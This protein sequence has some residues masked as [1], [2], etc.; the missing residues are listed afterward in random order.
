MKPLH[1][2][3]VGLLLSMI[4]WNNSQATPI[5]KSHIQVM[6]KI[7]I[8]AQYAPHQSDF[9]KSI[10][11]NLINQVHNSLQ[12]KSPIRLFGTSGQWRALD[13][14]QAVTQPGLHL[15][16][17][18]LTTDRFVKGT[19]RLEGIN[20]AS[21]YLNGQPISGDA[22]SYALQLIN[23]EHQVLIL[24][25][26]VDNWKKVSL[27]WET[28]SEQQSV[29]FHARAPQQRLTPQRLF[30]SQTIVD[31]SISPDGKHM[32][33]TKRHFDPVKGNQGIYVTELLTTKQ[34]QVIYRWEN[35]KLSEL[36]WSPDN[37]YI[38]YQQDEQL[39]LLNRH[40]LAIK[41]VAQQ[42][43]DASNFIWLNQD[44][45]VFN[46]TNQYSKEPGF[47]K[48][49]QA[50]EDRWLTWRDQTQVYK[51]DI[52]SG[53]ILQITAGKLSHYVTDVDDKNQRILTTRRP[54]DYTQPPHYVTE[55][56]EFNLKDATESL[57]GR[58]RYFNQA[59]Y[60][61]NGFY[62]LGGPDH[63]G[64]QGSI[65]TAEIAT[66]N[67]DGQLY[68]QNRNG[69][70]TPL[71]KNFTP[72]IDKLD[73]L[74]N[75][76]LLLLTI[77]KDRKHL[78]YYDTKRQKFNRI[79]TQLDV[80]SQYSVS[81][82]Y[83]PKLVYSGTTATAPQKVMIKNGSKKS[84]QLVDSQDSQYKG[85]ILSS[86][87]DWSYTNQAGEVI[88]GRYY[89]P[90]NFDS[91]R[92]YP[93]IVYYYG[94]TTPVTRRFTGRWPFSLWAAQGYVVYVMQPSGSIGYGQAFSAQHVNAWGQDTAE[95]IIASTKAFL[96]AHP[97]VDRQ[98]VANMGASYG[99]F[100]TMYLATKT[101]LFA[102]SIA[103]AGISNISSYW[104]HGW[105]GYLYSGIA[106]EGNFPWNAKRLY[107]DQS[108][109]YQ[110]DRINT[111]LLLLHGDADTNVPVSE[112]HQ[113]YTALKILGKDVEFVEF[114]GDDHHI[115]GRER[116]LRWWATILAYL[117][118]KLKGQ[119]LWWETLYPASS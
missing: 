72:S 50:L 46:W 18:E 35:K 16:K 66:N 33:W 3:F 85:V 8:Q 13:K 25:E 95:D 118:D 100:M 36:T 75:N 19:L 92:Q 43:K 2:Y 113:M 102:A 61:N 76:Q 94:G 17:L 89:L 71:S 47:T 38:A 55:L 26:Q 103:H 96:A 83:K 86:V 28:E 77:D 15:L 106:T 44:T 24:A 4:L 87:T 39:V 9:A 93:A 27:N 81:N 60:G 112:S 37:L 70:V 11:H 23:A 12:K 45:L 10:K 116:T 48:R 73:L 108:P 82:Q 65:L 7:A 64:D 99:G 84:K 69:Q 117:D 31:L 21:V 40:N 107:T 59:L 14:I 58:Y 101:D 79:N 29:T 32:I 104:G 105:W 34:Q 88:D 54:V 20:T 5:N 91:N 57:I 98:K 6:E 68:F 52:K 90:P 114:I 49:Y 111:P 119:P 1:L 74:A 30:D 109:L 41:T 51:L 97:F 78:Y 42:L 63:A 56:V 62:I 53:L 115:K 110:A 67:Y 22:D 80:I